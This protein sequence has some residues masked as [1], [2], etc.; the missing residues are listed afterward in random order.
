MRHYQVVPFG[1][2]KEEKKEETTQVRCHIEATPHSQAISRI[3]QESTQSMSPSIRV[4]L[5]VYEP[6]AFGV[7]SRSS[8]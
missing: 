8:S 4:T 6:L 2:K 7:N 3:P 5:H 1:S